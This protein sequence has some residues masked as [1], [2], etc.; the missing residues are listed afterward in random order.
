MNLTEVFVSVWL[1]PKVNWIELS[2]WLLFELLIDHTLE[3]GD[4]HKLIQVVCKVYE[5][6]LQN[7]IEAKFIKELM[8]DQLNTAAIR[9]TNP[10]PQKQFP[11]KT[12][13]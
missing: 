10:I 8:N 4:V 5:V 12:P 3:D 2:S 7:I 1:S 6:I 13:M 9:P 11:H